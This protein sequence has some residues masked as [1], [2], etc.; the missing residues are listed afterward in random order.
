MERTSAPALWIFILF[1]LGAQQFEIV[2][3][4]TFAAEDS[5]LYNLFRYDEV[6]AQ[7]PGLADDRDRDSGYPVHFLFRAAAGLRRDALG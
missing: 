2:I 4:E 1:N 3:F 7:A 5:R 6:T